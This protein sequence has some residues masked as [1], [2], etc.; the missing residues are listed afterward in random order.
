MNEVT[1]HRLVLE[2]LKSV[3]SISDALIRE[4]ITEVH[5]DVFVVFW[6]TENNLEETMP[7]VGAAPFI[8]DRLNNKVFPTGTGMPVS[9]FLSAFRDFGDPSAVYVDKRCLVTLV[10][11][12]DGAMKIAAT[13][14]IKLLEGYTLASAKRVV[15]DIL[16]D[17]EH[18]FTDLTCDEARSLARDLDKFCFDTKLEIYSVNK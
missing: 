2:Y 15:D 8:V 4:S 7:L 1:A 16:D 12:R 17:V 3:D 9:D 5:D 11:W 13:K 14:R 10:G 18:V 6:T